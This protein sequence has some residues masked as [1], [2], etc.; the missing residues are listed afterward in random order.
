[1]KSIAILWERCRSAAL[2]FLIM[3]ILFFPAI[4]FLLACEQREISE[5][6]AP[7]ASKTAAVRVAD[8]ASEEE[9]QS[10]AAK[11]SLNNQVPSRDQFAVQIIEGK[12][13]DHFHLVQLVITDQSSSSPKG[14]LTEYLEQ[15]D[16]L[17]SALR[18]PAYARILSESRLS[19][20]AR[21]ALERRLRDELRLPAEIAL[22]DPE[23]LVLKFLTEH[24]GYLREDH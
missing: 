15:A 2:P 10:P 23:A 9:N 13:E 8:R 21:G 20:L 5:V 7:D 14:L 16:V 11:T 12:P 4:L 19:P 3:K 18:L 22:D 6:K 24:S 17:D 1:M